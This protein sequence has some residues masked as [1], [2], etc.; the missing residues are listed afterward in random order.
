MCQ[1]LIPS[2]YGPSLF[3]DA[4]SEVFPLMERMEF[5]KLKCLIRNKVFHPFMI[6]LE[7]T[8]LFS[9]L[10]TMVAFIIKRL[11]VGHCCHWYYR[12]EN[13][14]EKIDVSSSTVGLIVCKCFCLM[15]YEA[16]TYHIGTTLSGVQTI[17]TV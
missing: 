7:A 11:T 9:V 13:C 4:Q 6:T 5:F 17:S 1:S 16:G 2:S 10:F 3:P 14:T 8:L 15:Q 12:N